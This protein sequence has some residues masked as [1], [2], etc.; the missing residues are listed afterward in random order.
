MNVPRLAICIG[1]KFGMK[2]VAI[3]RDSQKFKE[4]LENQGSITVD[5]ALDTI[6]NNLDFLQ[7][8]IVRVD[9]FILIHDPNAELAQEVRGVLALLENPTGLLRVK[10]YVFIYKEDHNI[11]H[12]R[13]ILNVVKEKI[14]E[15]LEANPKWEAPHMSEY[16]LEMLDYDSIYRTIMGKSTYDLIDPSTMIKYRQERDEDSQ[17]SFEYKRSDLSI[18]TKD[19]SKMA[20]YFKM[21]KML[22]AADSPAQ[23]YDTGSEI[24]EYESMVLELYTDLGHYGMK[25][26]IFTGERFSGSTTHMAALA[27]SA[28]EDGKSVFVL[29]L[30]ISGGIAY[31][32]DVAGTD[33]KRLSNVDL[34]DSMMAFETHRLCLYENTDSDVFFRLLTYVQN[35]PN[36]FHSDLLFVSCN[37]SKLDTVLSI[38]NPR[39][40]SV[41]LSSLLYGKS[42][43]LFKELDTQGART[44]VWLNDNLMS[45]TRYNKHSVD[46]FKSEVRRLHPD[47]KF[48]SPTFFEDFELGGDI[49]A[50]VEGVI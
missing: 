25:V 40:C 29:D 35:R 48:M 33:Y 23:I 45:P 10:E 36:I 32:L 43:Q 8:N 26:V 2:V 38:F 21:K 20:D 22:A 42:L 47:W 1:G 41:V 31:M 4:F 11:A 6:Y 24:P 9:K 28:V 5:Y 39:F 30:S 16:A 46:Y 19:A 3:C 15:K 17:K 18:H 13:Q 14:T 50:T 49:Y 12:N 44:L 7:N 27:V 34:L 37:L